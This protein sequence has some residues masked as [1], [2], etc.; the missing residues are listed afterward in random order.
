[1]ENWR[2]YCLL[3]LRVAVNL[4]VR[5]RARIQAGEVFSAESPI[6]ALR[7]VTTIL[8]GLLVAAVP[9]GYG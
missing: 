5:Q 3:L 8:R 6:L 1:M 2:K 9:R 4:P 7:V